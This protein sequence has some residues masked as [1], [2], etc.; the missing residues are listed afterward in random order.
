MTDQALTTN[1]NYYFS[2]PESAELSQ[3]LQQQYLG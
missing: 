2:T 1:Q 3:F